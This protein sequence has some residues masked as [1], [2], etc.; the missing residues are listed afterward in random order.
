MRLH[1]VH[2]RLQFAQFAPK[3]SI[4]AMYLEHDDNEKKSRCDFKRM[5]Q[6]EL[7][8]APGYKPI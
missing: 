4:L 8:G 2:T 7:L 6:D 1:R 3:C 5:Q